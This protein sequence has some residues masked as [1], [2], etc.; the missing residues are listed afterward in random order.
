M[1]GGLSPNESQQV[2]DWES[3]LAGQHV[4]A[5]M[6]SVLKTGWREAPAVVFGDSAATN[7][8]KSKKHTMIAYCNRY[9]GTD[10]MT[11]SRRVMRNFKDYIQGGHKIGDW[12]DAFEHHSVFPSLGK[13]VQLDDVS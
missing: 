9:L 6:R 5:Q 12:L 1:K 2:A 11:F 10:N 13:C 4:L 3:S 7:H 8:F